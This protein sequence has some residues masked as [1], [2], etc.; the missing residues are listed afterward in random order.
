MKPTRAKEPTI[1]KA[2]ASIAA[3]VDEYTQRGW[4]EQGKA[5]FAKLVK[6]RLSRFWPQYRSLDMATLCQLERQLADARK[7]AA[8][9]ESRHGRISVEAVAARKYL[10]ETES[11]YRSELAACTTD[12]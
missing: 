8:E 4:N 5:D 12:F 7:T 1:D 10:D 3:M 11:R 2:A 6:R 9:M